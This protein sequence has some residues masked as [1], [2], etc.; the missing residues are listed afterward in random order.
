VRLTPAPFPPG[1]DTAADLAR[2]E[3][4]LRTQH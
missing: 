1:I 4:W 3:Q 2:A